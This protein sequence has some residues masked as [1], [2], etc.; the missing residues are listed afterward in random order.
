MAVSLHIKLL[1]DI[2]D[3]ME[4]DSP[5]YINFVYNMT[6]F[7]PKGLLNSK[8]NLL[9]KFAAMKSKGKLDIGKYDNLKK[10]A[11]DSGNNDVDELIQEREQEIIEAL[12]SE[13]LGKASGQSTLTTNCG[14]SVCQTGSQKDRGQSS[15]VTPSAS[16][17]SGQ[18]KSGADKVDINDKNVKKRKHEEETDQSDPLYGVDVQ[19]R[20]KYDTD[21]KKGFLLIL[22]YERSGL[23]NDV[24]NLESFFGN[25]LG[26]DV[27]TVSGN[28]TASDIWTGLNETREKLNGDTKRTYYAFIC[29]ILSHGNKVGIAF[30]DGETISVDDIRKHF[31]NSDQT[32]NNFTGRPKL[33]FIQSC[34][35]DDV[36]GLHQV[37]EADDHEKEDIID[38]SDEIFNVPT[39]AD[40]LIAY[41]NTQGYATLGDSLDSSTQ[42]TFFINALLMVFKKFYRRDHVEEMLI[43]VRES[44][45]L[46]EKKYF[47]R[48]CKYSKQ[49]PCTWS[50]L[51]KRLYLT[52]FQ[53]AME[54]N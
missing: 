30:K 25:D 6:Q 44:L 54:Q 52:A 39:D 7:V 16:S 47:H 13:N 12:A 36:Q 8:P 43:S 4:T 28:L 23:G 24:R 50:T 31:I 51:T 11:K 45:A 41:A 14:Q 22:N 10:V 34:R 53:T 26:F 40:T 20:G 49:M 1:T 35:G 48:Q 19:G 2:S 27:K 21:G 29:V 9:G 5:E 15:S 32:M 17:R 42:F 38:E 37:D 46:G 3:M 33:F 18:I